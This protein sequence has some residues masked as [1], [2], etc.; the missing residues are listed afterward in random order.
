M[1]RSLI[2]LAVVALLLAACATTVP[3]TQGTITELDGGKVTVAAAGSQNTTFTVTRGTEVRWAS[4]LEGQRSALMTGQRV[5]VWS[6]N[7]SA[8]KIV[9]EP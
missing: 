6:D 4:G 8:T 1:K 2:L 3:S 9:I 5:Q 7:G